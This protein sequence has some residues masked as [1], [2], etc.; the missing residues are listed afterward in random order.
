[1]LTEYLNAHPTKR[2]A[3]RV[4]VARFSDRGTGKVDIVGVAAL[5]GVNPTAAK[6]GAFA[7]QRPARW[8]TSQGLDQ[9][10]ASVDVALNYWLRCL[11]ALGITQSDE[12]PQP[13]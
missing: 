12:V 5:V 7:S 9:G 6:A 2:P 10:I 11:S 13:A 1:V 8:S 4:R 3:A